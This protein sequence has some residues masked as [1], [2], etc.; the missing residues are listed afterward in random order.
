MTHVRIFTGIQPSGVPTLG[1]YLGVIRD[2]VFYKNF[3]PIRTYRPTI[4]NSLFCI[5]DLHAITMLPNP[6][7]LR[8]RTLEMAVSILATGFD[9]DRHSLFLQSDVSEHTE[10]GWII[11]CLT[12]IGWL[13]RMTQYKE[14]ATNTERASTGLFTY[15]CLMAADIMAYH[16]TFV[17]IG[18]DQQQHLSL[19]N[20]LRERFNRHVG[21]EFFPEIKSSLGMN[22]A[23]AK[24]MSLSDGTK[25][26]SKSDPSEFS[27]ILITDSAD[28]I[29]LKIRKAKTDSHVSGL[30][31][32]VHGLI[33]RPEMKNLANILA[34]L[35][36]TTIDNIL[37]TYGG[38][39]TMQ[40]KTA[41]TDKLISELEPIG[42]KY[43]ELMNNQDFVQKVLDNGAD[44][45][46]SIAEPI[47]NQAKQLMGFGRKNII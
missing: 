19:S 10:L 33:E 27:R 39:G 16:A 30:P 12:P 9:P 3:I 18:I 44:T 38:R 1:N 43:Q 23:C 4:E 21:V 7:L 2:W 5:A 41:L 47:V 40:F 28:Q 26:M 8:T 15:P 20:D 13:E 45:A 24:I 11:N 46:I 37:M 25:K 14:K 34:C 35:Q 42:K 29:Q 32:E 17:P 36:N 6:Q 31:S 22:P